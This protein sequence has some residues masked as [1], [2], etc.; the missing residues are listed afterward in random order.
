MEFT[1]RASIA[2]E[3]SHSRTKAC[4][5][6]GILCSDKKKKKTKALEKRKKEEK[7]KQVYN[8]AWLQLDDAFLGGLRQPGCCE[9]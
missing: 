8:H 2:A 9:T 5:Y 7:K 4:S 1:P 3:R 6:S